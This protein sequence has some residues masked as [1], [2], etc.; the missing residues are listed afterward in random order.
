MADGHAD[1]RG[2]QCSVQYNCC[3]VGSGALHCIYAGQQSCSCILVLEKKVRTT[4]CWGE[5][6]QVRGESQRNRLKR[7][8][9]CR[10]DSGGSA[11]AGVRAVVMVALR[12]GHRPTSLRE[13]KKRIGVTQGQVAKVHSGAQAS[14][15]T[16]SYAIH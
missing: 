10:R 12:G 1:L 7:Y 11:G 13:E 5:E 4:T 15:G 9:L 8:S 6:Q 16:L 3:L 14:R 2:R